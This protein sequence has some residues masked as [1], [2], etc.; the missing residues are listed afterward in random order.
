MYLLL[1]YA[2]VFDVVQKISGS[3]THPIE[4]TR[5]MYRSVVD[6]VGRGKIT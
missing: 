5:P 1:R 6:L 3:L 4:S 2:T